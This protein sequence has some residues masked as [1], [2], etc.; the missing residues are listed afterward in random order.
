VRDFSYEAS[1]PFGAERKLAEVQ[2]EL[3]VALSNGDGWGLMI[4]RSEDDR[5]AVAF[6]IPAVD[7]HDALR[8]GEEVMLVVFSSSP[9]F[10]QA[11]SPI[12]PEN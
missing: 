7:E 2:L 4:R 5:L 1:V 6:R 11:V 10:T 9:A 12:S 8:R 3:A